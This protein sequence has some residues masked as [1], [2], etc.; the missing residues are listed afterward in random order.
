MGTFGRFSMKQ[1]FWTHPDLVQFANYSE[2]LRKKRYF[3]YK[4]PKKGNWERGLKKVQQLAISYGIEYNPK[5]PFE[6]YDTPEPITWIKLKTGET[7]GITNRENIPDHV[8]KG[9]YH[10]FNAH[11]LDFMIYPIKNKKRAQETLIKLI[12]TF[13][14]ELQ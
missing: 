6:K 11:W 7:I 5:S 3:G 4:V 10:V 14:G 13:D 12:T 1:S 2:K 8:K 9:E